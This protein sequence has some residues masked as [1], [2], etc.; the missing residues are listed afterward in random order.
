MRSKKK[1]DKISPT[2]KKDV[3]F[4]GEKKK[5][6]RLHP[7]WYV[8]Q[9]NFFL[10]DGARGRHGMFHALATVLSA[11]ELPKVTIMTKNMFQ[12]LSNT[13][14][15]GLKRTLYKVRRAYIAARVRDSC[16]EFGN[17]I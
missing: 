4:H 5:R 1:T 15:N 8:E 16:G 3:Q 10:Q 14:L 12:R 6:P 13:V 11:H 9:A 17:V 7:C 2:L